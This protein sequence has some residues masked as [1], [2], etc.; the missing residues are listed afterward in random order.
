MQ[1]SRDLVGVSEVL[2]VTGRSGQFGRGLFTSEDFDL[3]PY[4]MSDVDRDWSDVRGDAR[5]L[6]FFEG[7]KLET[8][9]VGGFSF[10]FGTAEASLAGVCGTATMSERYDFGSWSPPGAGRRRTPSNAS[11]RRGRPMRRG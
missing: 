9:T 10:A 6:W 3:G 11:W 2:D 4:R 5:D 8:R 7:R 1:P